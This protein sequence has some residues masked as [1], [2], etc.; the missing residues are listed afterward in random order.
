MDNLNNDTCH[1]AFIRGE[2]VETGI[3]TPSPRAEYDN[4][5]DELLYKWPSNWP[6][7]H[8]QTNCPEC[9]A[10]GKMIISARLIDVMTRVY[11]CN[12]CDS[13]WRVETRS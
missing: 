7:F 9:G 13:F 5:E 6:V 4:F 8:E 2:V 3:S 1:L 10:T 12:R 11:S